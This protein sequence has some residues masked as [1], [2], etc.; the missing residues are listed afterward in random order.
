MPTLHLRTEIY[1][2]VEVCYFLSLSVDLH[3]L[4]TGK[5]GEHIV[6][7]V[8]QGVMKLGETVTW[9][10][11][12]FGIWQTLT[13]QITEANPPTYF[14]DEMLRGAFKSMRHEHHFQPVD[15][16]STMMTDVFAFASP[17]GILGKIF[18][19]LILENYMRRFLIERNQ[20]IKEVA[21]SGQWKEF[22]EPELLQS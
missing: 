18:N 9:K 6:A 12:H 13:T 20:T 4:S 15:T 7:G 10:A 19:R 1:A 8:R 17:F 11:R 22:I 16:S 2:P 3:Q 5:T 14:R 21:E